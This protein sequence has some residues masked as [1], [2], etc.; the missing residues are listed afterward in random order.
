MVGGQLALAMEPP[1]V[2]P[3]AKEG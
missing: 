3:S 2:E 1:T